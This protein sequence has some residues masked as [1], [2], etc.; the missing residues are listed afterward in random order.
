MRRTEKLGQRSSLSAD[1]DIVAYNFGKNVTAV[2]VRNW[3]AQKGL[4]VKDC[5][6]LTTSPEARFLTFK[7]TIQP[8]DYDRAT[9]DATL[10]PYRVGV[11]LFK[12]FNNRYQSQRSTGDDDGGRDRRRD[13]RR[14]NHMGIPQEWRESSGYQ[15]SQS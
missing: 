1:A 9:Q 10:W 8:E 13:N 15:N 3:L 7:I 5:K 4:H 2:D 6:L 11:R 12:S 14:G